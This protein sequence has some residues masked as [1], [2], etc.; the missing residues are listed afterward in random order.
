MSDME[1]V[2]YDNIIPEIGYFVSRYCTPSWSIEESVIDFIDLTYVFEGGA[3]YIINGVKYYVEKGDL[4]CIP[5]NSLRKAIPDSSNLMACYST[6]FQLNDISGREISLPFPL[7]SKIGIR[8]DLLNLYNELAIEWLEKAP[9]Y[10]MKSR[11]IFLM[12]LHRY[13]NLLYYKNSSDTIDPRIRKSIKYILG[14]FDSNIGVEDLA[15][16]VGLNPVYFGTLFKKNTGTTVREYINRIRVNNAE[17]MLSSGEYSVTETAY[18]CGFNDV[19]YFSKV[20]KSYK[21]YCPSE[22]IVGKRR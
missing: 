2:D 9:G 14:N 19:F 16:L 13:F 1:Y 10:K 4:I 6:N 22:A 11:A 20:F 3:Y 21:G 7:I 15:K 17:N 12:V 18:R 5:K 8:D